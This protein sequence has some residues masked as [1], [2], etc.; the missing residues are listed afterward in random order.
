MAGGFVGL[1]GYQA[2]ST[3]FITGDRQRRGLGA[4]PPEPPPP[5]QEARAAARVRNGGS[6][7]HNTDRL[8]GGWPKKT[9]TWATPATCP[10]V[11]RHQGGRGEPAE[12]RKALH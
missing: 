7:F 3:P 6:P 8:T 4:K 1:G 11:R 5:A 9:C 10:R 2:S 12:R